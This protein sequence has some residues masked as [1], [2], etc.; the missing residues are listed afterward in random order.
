MSWF[1]AGAVVLALA[2]P[3]PL[4]EGTDLGD[5][6]VGT[7][8]PDQVLAKGG[9][10]VIFGLAE[11]DRIDGG[12]GSDRLHGDGVCPPTAVRPDDC[13]DADD[14]AGEADVLRGGDGDD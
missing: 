9:D 2:A 3:A 13:T 1:A 4:I 14:R 5:F 6:L 8:G 7:A 10:D 12:P 11:A